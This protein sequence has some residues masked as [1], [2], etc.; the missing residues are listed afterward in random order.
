VAFRC[1]HFLRSIPA[2]AEIRGGTRGN[3]GR[4][5][6]GKTHSLPS[7]GNSDQ[8]E[9]LPEADIGSGGG[10]V[11][12]GATSGRP[13]NRSSSIEFLKLPLICLGQFA[14]RPYPFS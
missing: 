3:F 10:H 5:V 8:S 6:E 7:S 11:G 13:L 2:R 14:E 12:F 4:E 9:L 1:G